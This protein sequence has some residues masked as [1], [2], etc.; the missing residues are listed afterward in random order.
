MNILVGV[1]RIY[2]PKK[3]TNP[4]KKDPFEKGSY[5]LLDDYHQNGEDNK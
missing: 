3:V 5:I 2:A 1:A 4:T